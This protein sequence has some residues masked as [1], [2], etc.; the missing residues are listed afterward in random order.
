[1]YVPACAILI[2]ILTSNSLPGF[3]LTYVFSPLVCI[4]CLC[5]PTE[6]VCGVDLLTVAFM[7]QITVFYPLFLLLLLL[8]RLVIFYFDFFSTTLLLFLLHNSNT[9]T[10]DTDINY[11][12][13]D[14]ILRAGLCFICSASNYRRPTMS[15]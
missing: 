2:E 12:K 11:I 14:L 5:R 6:T 1:M 7:Q 10:F 9:N 3:F 15:T 8:P 4:M 13:T